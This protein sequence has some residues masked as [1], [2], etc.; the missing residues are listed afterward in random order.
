MLLAQNHLNLHS[1]HVAHDN[2]TKKK[3]KIQNQENLFQNKLPSQ[4]YRN[5]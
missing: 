4:F 5:L 3:K 2:H 1:K